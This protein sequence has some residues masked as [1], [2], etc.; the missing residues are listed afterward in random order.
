MYLS[1]RSLGN[2]LIVILVHVPSMKHMCGK[3]IYIIKQG[4]VFKLV[5]FGT[6]G[7]TIIY[8]HMPQASH[9]PKLTW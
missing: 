5:E 3:R 2:F 1:F 7:I 8:M 4:K 9:T 6:E